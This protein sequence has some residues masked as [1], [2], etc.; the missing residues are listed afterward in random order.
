[1]HA[2]PS[3]LSSQRNQPLIP[4]I[5]YTTKELRIPHQ[6]RK[7][8]PPLSNPT[9]RHIPTSHPHILIS[10]TSAPPTTTNQLLLPPRV[11]S[12]LRFH[13]W[14]FHIIRNWSSTTRHHKCRTIRYSAAPPQPISIHS[15]SLEKPKNHP[16]LSQSSPL[17]P[18]K[19]NSYFD[20]C[21]ID[22]LK[23]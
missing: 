5:C 9:C 22:H 13:L 20:C 23:R 11:H 18:P 3:F 10:A 14:P 16:H 6:N 12:C 4:R 7:L 17:A 19:P 8:D 2:S 1:M 15:P 21:N